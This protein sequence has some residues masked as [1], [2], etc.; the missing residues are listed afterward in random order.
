MLIS[1]KGEELQQMIEELHR[2]SRRV[3]LSMNMKKTKVMF[4]DHAQ[5]Q[6]INIMNQTLEEVNEYVYLGQTISTAPGHEV[7]IKRRI[8]L[9][10]RAFGKQSDIMKSKIPLSLKKK[11]FNQL[12]LPVLTYGSETWSLTKAMERKLVSTQRAMERIMM[13]IILKDGKKA[14]WIR[15]QTKAE[16]TIWT[17]KKKK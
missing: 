11:V 17:I 7:E 6:Q 2:E 16:D 12:I 9:G 1:E 13:G 14:T 15:E 3:G 5:K 10:W 8:S 4:N